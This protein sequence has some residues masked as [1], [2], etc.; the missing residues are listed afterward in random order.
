[1]KKRS[2]KARIG[3]S[4]REAKHV[5]RGEFMGGRFTCTLGTDNL[6]GTWGGDP[7][8]CLAPWEAAELEKEY[9]L[10]LDGV[11]QEI[12]DIRGERLGTLRFVEGRVT[13]KQ[14]NP[15]KEAA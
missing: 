8:E 6:Q 13:T 5:W 15:R 9:F 7:F 3:K 10:W 11:Y 14:F 1:M 4:E 2:K 12:A